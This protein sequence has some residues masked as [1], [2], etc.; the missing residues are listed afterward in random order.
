M[1]FLW[2]CLS[3]DYR[4]GYVWL[5]WDLNWLSWGMLWLSWDMWWFSWDMM[6]VYSTSALHQPYMAWKISPSCSTGQDG[7][8]QLSSPQLSLI[9][10][11]L[12]D[13]C[14][15]LATLIKMYKS[16]HHNS[17]STLITHCGL[18]YQS[19]WQHWVKMEVYKWHHTTTL[20]QSLITPTDLSNINYFRSLSTPAYTVYSI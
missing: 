18:K 20:T 15:H 19:I 13:F 1:R 8:V 10:I 2:W 16:H 11:T 3:W 17:H 5:I 14:G 9:I 12:S 7:S 6:E 4:L